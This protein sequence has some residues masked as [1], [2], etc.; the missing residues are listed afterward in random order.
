MFRLGEAAPKAPQQN[1]NASWALTNEEVE[2][3]LATAPPLPECTIHS[4]FPP[5]LGAR[6]TASRHALAYPKRSNSH[7]ILC[8]EKTIAKRASRVRPRADSQSPPRPTR[9][10][11]ASTSWLPVAPPPNMNV[12][13]APS[14]VQRPRNGPHS[15]RC[16]CFRPRPNL[17]RFNRL[18]RA[19]PAEPGPCKFSGSSRCPACPRTPRPARDSKKWSPA[20]P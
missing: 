8:T 12:A 6:N 10:S 11:D 1:A 17:Q 13:T 3:E 4:S 2:L 15:S 14:A 16:E 9:P 5:P 18:S 7:S 19:G 20:L